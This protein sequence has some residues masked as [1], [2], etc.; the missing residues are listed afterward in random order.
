M[1]PF[2][3]NIDTRTAGDILYEI[4]TDNSNPELLHSV[5]RFIAKEKGVRFSG[6]W[7]LVTEW[8][9]VPQYLGDY[10]GLVRSTQL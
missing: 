9:N 2:W 10:T 8:N 7:M 5:S 3:A 1:A 4:H 6:R